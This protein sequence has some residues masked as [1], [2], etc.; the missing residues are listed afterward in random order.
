MSRYVINF[1]NSWEEWSGYY[2]SLQYY[3]VLDECYEN[4]YMEVTYRGT[5]AWVYVMEEY[6]D[7]KEE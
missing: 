3:D 5:Y 4:P 6:Y 1:Y 7:Q 2:D